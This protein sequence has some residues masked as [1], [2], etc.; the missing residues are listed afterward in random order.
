MLNPNIE[1]KLETNS[2]FEFFN[3][4]KKIAHGFLVFCVS[5]I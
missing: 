4:Q 3:I 1:R 2:N 5:V